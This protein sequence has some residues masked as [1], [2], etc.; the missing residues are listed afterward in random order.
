MGGIIAF[1]PTDEMYKKASNLRK[2]IKESKKKAAEIPKVYKGNDI[3]A[4]LIA[5]CQQ[6]EI[7][8]KRKRRPKERKNPFTCWDNQLNGK[9]NS[10]LNF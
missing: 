2:T 10:G 7:S 3:P 1:E 5:K 9:I 6:D 8:H 4:A